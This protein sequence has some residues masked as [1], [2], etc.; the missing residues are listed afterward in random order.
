MEIYDNKPTGGNDLYGVIYSRNP[1]GKYMASR[2]GRC[3]F[4]IAENFAWAH[5]NGT[6]IDW[7]IW[8][9]YECVDNP[10]QLILRVRLNELLE[11]TTLATPLYLLIKQLSDKAHVRGV[12]GFKIFLWPDI[13]AFLAAQQP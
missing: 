4:P 7:A 2:F 8:A 3:Q 9:S 5:L 10:T 11:A 13:R 12:S 6:R 1:N